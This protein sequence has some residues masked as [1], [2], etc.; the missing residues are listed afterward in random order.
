MVRV[1]RARQMKRDGYSKVCRLGLAH[2]IASAQV[3]D[4]ITS[5]CVA[6]G[7]LHLCTPID[8]V[9]LL[10]A[11]L[12]PSSA[13]RPTSYLP[14]EDLFDS[15]AARHYSNRIQ[16]YN[17]LVEKMTRT[18][19]NGSQTAVEQQVQKLDADGGSWGDIVAFGK[20]PIVRNALT[21]CCDVQGEFAAASNSGS[22]GEKCSPC[23][24]L[25]HRHLRYTVGVSS[26][27]CKDQ[28]PATRQA[29]SIVH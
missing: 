21:R 14:L 26:I 16:S 25:L 9:F 20:L 8:P 3:A 1:V 18:A 29:G 27:C 28:G 22:Y 13:T 12:E 19:S 11:L 23:Q 7:A 17:E 10:L 2:A 24:M 4:F 6:D 5:F 15:A